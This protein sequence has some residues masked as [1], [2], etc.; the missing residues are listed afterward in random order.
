[1]FFFQNYWIP[2]KLL[3]LIESPNTFHWKP[4]KTKE[5]VVLGQNLVKLGPMFEKKVKKLALSIGFFSYLGWEIP[6]KARSSG[7][8][9][10]LV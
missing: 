10:T 6:F 2:I 5:V 8:A 7:Y 1:M 4:A 3:I 9:I